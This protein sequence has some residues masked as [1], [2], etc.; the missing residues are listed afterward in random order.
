MSQVTEKPKNDPSPDV[1]LM[2]QWLLSGDKDLFILARE[3]DAEPW[4]EFLESEA[5]SL[6]SAA[7]PVS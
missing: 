3:L 7:Q 4:R 1:Q 6:R 5:A 2:D